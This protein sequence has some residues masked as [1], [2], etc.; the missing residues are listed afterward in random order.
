MNNSL[1]EKVEK[2]SESNKK[3]L[4]IIIIA[5]SI[6]LISIFGAIIAF[7]NLNDCSNI[8]YSEIMNNLK[9]NVEPTIKVKWAAQFEQ[10]FGEKVSWSGWIANVIKRED[11]YEV[12]IDMDSPEVVISIE[13][14]KLYT[15]DKN[16]LK[17]NY[18]QHITFEGK[19][20]DIE[21]FFN[22]YW[23]ELDDGKIL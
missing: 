2:I 20:K 22:K 14:V 13:D 3:K 5:L 23:I 21:G 16:V 19:I 8:T 15:K 1:Q 7:G 12:L 4:N 9:K 11:F 6:I 18:D 10:Y 17:L